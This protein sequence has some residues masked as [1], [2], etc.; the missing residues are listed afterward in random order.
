MVDVGSP[1][2]E[3]QR[4]HTSQI[5]EDLPPYSLNAPCPNVKRRR[6]DECDEIVDTKT[7]SE[8]KDEEKSGL[9]SCQVPEEENGEF[10]WL[11]NLSQIPV[12]VTSPTL[13]P[14]PS[15]PELRKSNPVKQDKSRD[16]SQQFKKL[17]NSV[18][19]G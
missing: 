19:K 3:K 5:D 15:S 11:H 13:E 4:F 1:T 14:V 7:K 2:Y 8:S 16:I 6:K 9:E 12:F 18:E 17:E 10:V